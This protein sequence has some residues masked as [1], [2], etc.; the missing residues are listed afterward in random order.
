MKNML[1]SVQRASD[2]YCNGLSKD[3][4]MLKIEAGKLTEQLTIKEITKL[5]KNI[6]KFDHLEPL[7]LEAFHKI[8]N[9]TKWENVKE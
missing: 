5:S 6:E 7:Q 2:D 4:I 1:E 3:N 9:K 8:N